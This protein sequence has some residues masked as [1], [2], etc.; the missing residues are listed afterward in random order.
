MLDYF[1]N[2]M[3]LALTSANVPSTRISGFLEGL[4]GSVSVNQFDLQSANELLRKYAPNFP[5]IARVD[6]DKAKLDID[7]NHSLGIKLIG[8]KDSAYPPYLK[9]IKDAPP[10][11]F[12]RGNQDVLK[13]LPG[14]AIV[15]ARDA[16]VNGLE[17][18][19]RLAK[20]CVE[21][22]WVVVSGLALGIDAAAHSGALK[23]G[24]KT[25]A[26]LAGGLEKATPI[27]NARLAQDILGNGGAWVSEHSVGIPPKKHHFVP[28][29]RIQIGL[30]VG[31]IIVEA[32]PRSGSFS[33]A[34][35]CV[36]N[37]R[38]LFAV[39]P[40]TSM[41]PLKLNSEGTLEMVNEL[42]AVAVKTKSDYPS[43]I[44]SMLDKRAL[45]STS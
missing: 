42:G 33:Q 2:N 12:V 4:N 16:T 38:V 39:T 1:F 27:A 23:G 32:K 18:A 21:N 26:V 29:N 13:K 15:G 30:S 36:G 25:I 40:E 37:N 24:G 22:D 10:I 6:W 17:I 20:Y 44:Q 31:S 7:N 45:L 35:F 34:K 19:R 43:M 28:R 41:N 11:L 3:S 5:E 8:Y 14:I 9:A